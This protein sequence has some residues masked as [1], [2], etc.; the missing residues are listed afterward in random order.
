MNIDFRRKAKHVNRSIGREEIAGSR[1]ARYTV[2]VVVAVCA[3]YFYRLDPWHLTTFVLTGSAMG[4]FT[5]LVLWPDFERARPAVIGALVGGLLVSVAG[6]IATAIWDFWS[7]RMLA[8]IA[9]RPPRSSYGHRHRRPG[10]IDLGASLVLRV[11]LGAFGDLLP[12]AASHPLSQ[13]APLS[14]SLTMWR[15]PIE[16]FLVGVC[17][18]T[19]VG[20]GTAVVLDLLLDVGRR[21][22][23]RIARPAFRLCWTPQSRRILGKESIRI[24]GTR[25]GEA[26]RIRVIGG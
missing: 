26:N 2:F 16:S 7:L 13:A 10:R 22:I 14:A 8:G 17:L 24:R 25:L 19:V 9:R 11:L 1:A 6:E 21:L 20:G 12:G 5:T 18:T 15:S 4:A 3:V 23:E